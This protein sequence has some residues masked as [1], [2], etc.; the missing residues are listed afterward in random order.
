M[1]EVRGNMHD[2]LSENQIRDDEKDK[3]YLFQL[4]NR[5]LA[6]S[7]LTGFIASVH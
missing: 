2:V 5:Y 1:Q 6:L 4:Q 7:L 3:R